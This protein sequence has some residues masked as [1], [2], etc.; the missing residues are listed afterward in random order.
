LTNKL[1]DKEFKYKQVI[2]TINQM[3]VCLK[4]IK[5]KKLLIGLTLLAS[6]SSFAEQPIQPD[7]Y[8]LRMQEEDTK[9][10]ERVK[11]RL[12][13]SREYESSDCV[14]TELNKIDQEV[15][16][17]KIKYGEQMDAY[18]EKIMRE[19]LQI[20]ARVKARTCLSFE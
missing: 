11:L 5:M 15:E 1:K 12:E 6:M 4:D 13:L 17:A 7:E 8:S 3:S 19:D 16:D 2:K 10:V 9:M 14:Q 18:S 20:V